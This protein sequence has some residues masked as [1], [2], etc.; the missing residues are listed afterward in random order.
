MK[1]LALLAMLSAHGTKITDT[2][3]CTPIIQKFNG[4]Q[5]VEASISAD[6]SLDSWYVKKVSSTH[7]DVF[8]LERKTC[9]GPYEKWPTMAVD[10]TAKR[11][12][13]GKTL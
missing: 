1:L 11:K 8:R 10:P 2:S 9:R 13:E 4:F 7:W 6:G 5:L 12:S 3:G